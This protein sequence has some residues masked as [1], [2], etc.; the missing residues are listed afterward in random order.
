MLTQDEISRA[1]QSLVDDW[2]KSYPT[3]WPLLHWLVYLHMEQGG[4]VHLS[5]KFLLGLLPSP[6]WWEW[7]VGMAMYL[8]YQGWGHQKCLE[9][10]HRL[11]FEWEGPPNG[12]P[13]EVH[14]GNQWRLD[15]DRIAMDLMAKYWFPNEM[16]QTPG[17][18]F[19]SQGVKHQQAAPPKQ[20]FR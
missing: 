19:P 3:P 9:E 1:I 7:F 16:S 4:G 14:V 10:L 12:D 6:E 17:T 2:K 20:V 13:Q 18:Y 5:G 11:R 15:R 8:A